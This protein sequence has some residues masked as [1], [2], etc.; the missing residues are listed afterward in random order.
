M[1]M[2]GIDPGINGA[3]ALYVAV[4]DR[5][6]IADVIDIPTTGDKGEAARRV[7]GSILVDWI[8][9]QHATHAYIENVGSMPDQGIASAFRFGRAVG[10]IECAVEAARVP[11]TLV[12]PVVWKKMFG[13]KGPDKEQSRQLAARRFPD[14]TRWLARK[15]DHQRAE[16][17]LIAE[18]G[19][20]MEATRGSLVGV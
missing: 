7:H 18:F 8:R 3:L 19:A 17:M 12:S 20:K 13:L 16:A 5:A 15:L 6:F 14:A 4:D 11:F 9:D 2:L 1:R 10:A